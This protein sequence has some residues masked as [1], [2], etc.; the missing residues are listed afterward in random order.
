MILKCIMNSQ[1]CLLEIENHI[2]TVTLNRVQKLN[3]LDMAMFYA[4]KK[5]IKQISK[6]AEVR[7]VILKANGNDFSTGLDMKSV[8]N[9]SSNV[10]KLLWKWWPYSA[11][12]AQ[13]VS[14]GW[15]RLKVPVI[16]CVQGRCWGGGLQIALGAD[17]IIANPNADFS[18]MESKWGLIPDMAG[19]LGLRE[20]MPL[21]QAMK[22][23]MT[24]QNFGSEEAKSWGMLTQ[25]ASDQDAAGKAL[26]EDLMQ[27]S[28]DAIAAIKKLYHRAWHKNDAWLLSRETLLQWKMIFS[29]NRKIAVYNALNPSPKAF[30]NL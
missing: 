7:V 10:F 27:K 13:Y 24:S 17:F 28:P 26:A 3:G 9:K 20:K 14:V 6:T 23:A 11:N 8:M 4:I 2:A 19:S 5:C 15:R 18:I 30:K 1:L 16:C 29:K 21:D 22:L 25:I 12:L